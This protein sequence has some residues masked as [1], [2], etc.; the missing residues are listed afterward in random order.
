MNLPG[1]VFIGL[2]LPFAAIDLL[3]WLRRWR[4]H[5]TPIAESPICVSKLRMF[6]DLFIG[7]GLLLTW[8]ISLIE[9][10]NSSRYWNQ[11]G[12]IACFALFLAW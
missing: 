1:I 11:V 8:I 9:E 6:A 3:I 5:R 10:L 12:L 7:T 4:C 2:S